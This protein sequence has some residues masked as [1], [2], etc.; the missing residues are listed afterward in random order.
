MSEMLLRST[1]IWL[2]SLEHPSRFHFKF[3]TPP[4]GSPAVSPRHL[5]IKAYHVDLVR[6]EVERTGLKLE[7]IDNMVMLLHGYLTGKHINA[8]GTR[9]FE[10]VRAEVRAQ[11]EKNFYLVLQPTSARGC[12]EA[13]K[14]GLAD[15]SVMHVQ[16][17]LQVDCM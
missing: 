12:A 7:D 14:Y 17:V 3:P 15:S 2:E 11:A 6:K 1:S 13:A 9:S 8:D 4:E 16:V 5:K 10:E